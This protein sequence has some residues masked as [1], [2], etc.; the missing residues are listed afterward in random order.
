MNEVQF[1]IALGR[2]PEPA[3]PTGGLAAPAIISEIG[4][5][6]WVMDTEMGGLVRTERKG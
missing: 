5:R 6:G 1:L 3:R 2:K 4:T